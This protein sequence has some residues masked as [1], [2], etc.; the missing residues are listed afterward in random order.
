MAGTDFTII[1]C[2]AACGALVVSECRG[3]KTSR[4]IFKTAASTA[5][6]ALAVQLDATA[7]AYGQLILV[8][9]VLSWVGDVLLLSQKSL[10]FLLGLASF[11]LAHVVFSGAFALRPID[12]TALI[13]G[14]ALMSCIGI[15]VLVW[16]WH[17]LKTFY[18]V[19][20]T[21]YVMA[22]VAMCTLAI[23]VSAASGAWLLASGALIFALS[24]I[25]VA[26]DRFVAPGS[27]NR[28]WGLPLYYM[29]QIIF[30]LSL[31]GARIVAA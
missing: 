4:A 14:L 6:L 30:A 31:G 19:A 13:V 25:A 16:L 9:L 18:R 17:H 12:G 15:S 3:W 24:D 5:F 26:R 1:A 20:V 8:A 23:A 27:I 2:L 29:A 21:A 7:S 10:V 22:I 28:V 11:L